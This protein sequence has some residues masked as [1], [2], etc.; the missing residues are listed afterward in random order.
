MIFAHS[1]VGLPITYELLKKENYSKEFKNL[2]YFV[3]ITS[4][5]LPDFDLALGIFIHDLNHRQLISHSLI[6][7]LLVFIILYLVSIPLKKYQK[8]LRILNLIFFLGVCSHLFL[9]FVAGGLALFSPFYT[10]IVG[11]VPN[12]NPYP[13]FFV[14]YFSSVYLL[15][16]FLFLGIYLFYLK[17]EKLEIVYYLPLTFLFIALTAMVLYL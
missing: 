11:I 14:S 17:K 7:Y 13:N 1:F 5:V 6:P 15:L 3:G 8:R 2:A 12:F 4:A 10:G 16:E 9:D